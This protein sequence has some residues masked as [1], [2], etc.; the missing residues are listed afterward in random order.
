MDLCD[1]VHEPCVNGYNL[2]QT[3]TAVQLESTRR[4][5]AQHMAGQPD[6]R[7]AE[8]VSPAITI[9]EV[10]QQ[11]PGLMEL[12]TPEGV[13]ALTA[14]CK[15]LRQGLRC[16]VTTSRIANHQATAMLHADK[17]PSLVMVVAYHVEQPTAL[18]TL[19]TCSL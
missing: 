4:L 13:K 14:T 7:C 8:P 12:L 19:I 16:S 3:L 17:W 1:L 5:S 6:H 11:A 2:E 9:F 10:V 18:E 15:Q